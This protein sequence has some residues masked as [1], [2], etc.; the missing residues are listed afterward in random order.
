MTGL[1][2]LGGMPRLERAM[3]RFVGE[4]AADFVI[5]FLFAGKD[6]DRIARHEAELAA[7]L[8]GGDAPYTGRPLA[9]LH[10]PMRVHQGQFRRRLFLLRRVLEAEGFAHEVVDAWIAHHQAMA[11]AIVVPGDCV[12]DA[13][14]DD[15]SGRPE[16]DRR[17]D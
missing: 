2:R 11:T 6:L 9:S 16:S 12:P 15:T 10:R 1:D 13:V 17:S 8:F 3:Q 14:A 4:M 7:A 5:G